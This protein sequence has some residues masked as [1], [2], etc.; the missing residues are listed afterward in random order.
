M[1][2]VGNLDNADQRIVEDLHQFCATAA[3]LFGRTFKPLL[4]VVLST[5]R[6][7]ENMGYGGLSILYGYF[8]LSGVV[9]RAASPPFSEYIARTQK[10][11]GDF[12]RMHS[13]LI[14]HA[15]EVAFLDGAGRERAILDA[16]LEST[17]SWSQFYF[18]LQFKQGV[19]DQYF[20]KYFA[21]MIGWPVLAFPFLATDRSAVSP[22]QI[23]ARYRESDTLIQSAS[24][25]IGDL[26]MVYK[27]LQR[28]AGFTARVVELLEAV[29][30]YHKDRQDSNDK[31]VAIAAGES[32]PTE[33][34]I[35]ARKVEV[36]S[37]TGG[38]VR[39]MVAAFE[40][41]NS[42]GP[43]TRGGAPE[44]GDGAGVSRGSARGTDGAGAAGGGGCIISGPAEGGV[45]FDGVTVLSPDGR[46]LVRDVTFA[47]KPGDN[48]F[49]TGANG[50]GK[51]SLFRVLAGLWW[52]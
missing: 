38:G 22:A 1:L 35:E 31:A 37:P 13:R 52:G 16:K 4:D 41:K 46:L 50:A 44:A 14:T 32:N 49:V 3:D 17:T 18:Y 42:P 5:A 39:S 24:S 29:D 11:E 28:L 43:K 30:T 7:G 6:M 9:I 15:E 2:R 47:L 12:R 27:K 51:T 8:L 20:V 26:L 40:S 21:S 34:S 23:A 48:L 36:G 19:V 25:S 45:R 10:L 33:I